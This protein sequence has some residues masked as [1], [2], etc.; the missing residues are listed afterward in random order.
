[1]KTFRTVFATAAFFCLCFFGIGTILLVTEPEFIRRT[2]FY[3]LQQSKLICLVL[4][5]SFLLVSIILS[6]AIRKIGSEPRSI[7]R[8]DNIWDE[9]DDL[10]DTIHEGNR[11]T[12]IKNAQS[13]ANPYRSKKSHPAKKSGSINSSSDDQFSFEDCVNIGADYSRGSND[14]VINSNTHCPYC[15][16]KISQNSSFCNSCGKRL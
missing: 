10:F 14:P 4:G 7:N 11:Q 16:A 5:I 2:I 1:M 15:G 3:L 8:G 13:K 12:E 6:I 9:D